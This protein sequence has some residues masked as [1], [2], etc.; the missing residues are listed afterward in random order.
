MGQSEDFVPVVYVLVGVPGSGK[1]T[2]VAN[3][4]WA[5]E[6]VLISSDQLIEQE[7][8]RCNKTYDD[9]FQDFADIAIEKM[10]DAVADARDAQ[11]NIIWDQT[12]VDA[13]SRRLKF[14]ALPGYRH[15]AI[16]FP[17]PG[18]EELA[19]RLERPGKT[20]PVEVVRKMINRFTVP[21][22]QE[23]YDEIWTIE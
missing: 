18:P 14:N 2:W 8:R 13:R 9:V 23:G 11:K 4:P 16:V 1:S 6:C 19:R 20:I 10:L 12:S 21:T 5:S 7:A 15:V 3:Q 17:I 22:K